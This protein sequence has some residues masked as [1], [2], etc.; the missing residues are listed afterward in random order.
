MKNLIPLL[1][2]A[3]MVVACGGPEEEVDPFQVTDPVNYAESMAVIEMEVRNVD[4]HIIGSQYA[5][6]ENEAEAVLDAAKDLGKFYPD[7]IAP[8]YEAYQEYE[9]EAE[10]LRRTS[11]RLLL[12]IQL[13]RKE[14]AKDQLGELARRYNLLSSKYGPK[15]QI[16][17]LER[18]ADKFRGAE[19]SEA[20]VP[21]ELT[22]NR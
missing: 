9:A 22:G 13:R 18:G 2:L 12:M 7:T 1:M 19:Y 16:G 14:D 10:D 15:V 5:M 8:N 21:G 20:N 17:V 4:V 3:L 6:A 11:D